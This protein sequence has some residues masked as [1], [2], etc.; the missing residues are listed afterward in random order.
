MTTTGIRGRAEQAGQTVQNLAWRVAHEK[1]GT[2]PA[3]LD[4]ERVPDRRGPAPT[5]LA[6]TSRPRTVAVTVPAIVSPLSDVDDHIDH[7]E[8]ERRTS[9][10]PDLSTCPLRR[11]AR[12]VLKRR[13][14]CPEREPTRVSML[15]PHQDPQQL[16]RSG[17]IK[18]L[19]IKLSRCTNVERATRI[20]LA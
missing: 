20:E 11:P 6:G 16:L 13:R 4:T 1:A 14:C 9:P 5:T 18:S 8:A 12:Q 19:L 15:V 10:G 7:I 2:L 17:S 3:S